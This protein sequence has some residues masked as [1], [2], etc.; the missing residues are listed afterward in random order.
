MSDVYQGTIERIQQSV[1]NLTGQWAFLSNYSY[2]LQIDDLTNFGRQ[3][4]VA[5]GLAFYQRYRMLASK[6]EAF[7]R[8]SSSDRV[9][10]SA[11]LFLTGFYQTQVASVTAAMR[12]LDPAGIHLDHRPPHQ[13]LV[14]TE[15]PSSNNT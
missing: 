10:E 9:V 8:A 13:I 4:M 15:G 2:D 5:S 14:I 6:H 1:K 12:K 7:V 11:E 3:E